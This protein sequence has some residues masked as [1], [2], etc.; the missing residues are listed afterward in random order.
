MILAG[1]IGGT[2][3]NLARFEWRDGR[4]ERLDM[5]TFVSRDFPGLEPVVA[6]F[7]G[8]DRTPVAAACFGI[9][10]PVVDGRCETTN[11]PWVVDARE[12]QRHLGIDRVWLLND[13]E[14][15]G[16]GIPA[17]EPHELYTLQEGHAGTG[18]AGLIAA[19]TGLGECLLFWNGALHT[20]SPSEGGHSDFAP[21]NAWEVDLWRFLAHRYGHV[22]YERILSGP[23]FKELYDFLVST[24]RTPSTAVRQAVAEAPNPTPI[25]SEAGLNHTDDVCVEL[26]DRFVEIYGAE[27][28]NIA[29]KA[30]TIAGLYIGGGI[31][32][33]ILPR[34]KE[35]GFL[36]AF[37]D[38]GRFRGLM[39]RIPVR[40]I[41]NPETALLG[42][43]RY[44]GLA[45]EAGLR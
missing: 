20:P 14:A 19:G 21:R 37:L 42:A 10:G 15:T 16:Y 33:R 39:E 43:A 22:S 35:G 6:E 12:V 2:K 4:L 40:V 24:G 41:L 13:L 3:T 34:L 5:A 29:L 9:A 17:L 30:L 25:I 36:R 18:N 38:K 32:P 7:L 28:G 8:G 27:A 44:A 11:L 31:A 45:L 1:D 23:G 26:L